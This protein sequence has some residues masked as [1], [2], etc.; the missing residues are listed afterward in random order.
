M[1][2]A[3]NHRTRLVAEAQRVAQQDDIRSVVVQEAARLAHGGTGDV[4]TEWFEDIF[5]K[6]LA[7]YHR[8]I[9]E[10]QAQQAKQ[11]RILTNIKASQELYDDPCC[12]NIREQD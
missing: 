6:E 10:M 3:R 1:E 7:K 12:A 4:Q 5:E 8:L 9:E 11:E 2:D